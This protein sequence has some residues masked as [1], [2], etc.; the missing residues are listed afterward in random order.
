MLYMT[1]IFLTIL[2]WRY[3]YSHPILHKETK[4]QWLWIMY[5]RSHSSKVVDPVSLARSDFSTCP[6]SGCDILLSLPSLL[7]SQSAFFYLDLILSLTCIHSWGGD[8][9]AFQFF[10]SDRPLLPLT[11]FWIQSIGRVPVLSPITT[12]LSFELVGDLGPSRSC[13]S[14][15][16]SKPL[17]CIRAEFWAQ[18]CL[19]PLP[20]GQTTITLSS[21]V[22][23][24]W[25]GFSRSFCSTL[26][27]GQML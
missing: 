21:S 17:F 16:S 2:W 19:L 27:L 10:S 3:Y 8:F 13:P 26:K 5:P 12:K 14:P 9:S 7:T 23:G 11:K 6:S 25:M 15:R 4:A 24:V 22:L 18:V 1:P 20:H